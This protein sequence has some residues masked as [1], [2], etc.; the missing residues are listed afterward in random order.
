MNNETF[1]SDAKPQSADK[2][3]TVAKDQVA[4]TTDEDLFVLVREKTDKQ[5]F[6]R[7]TNA[8]T[9]DCLRIAFEAMKTRKQQKMCSKR[10]DAGL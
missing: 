2:K 3:M 9:N 6:E 7:S 5:A 8:T 4:D 1:I 10:H